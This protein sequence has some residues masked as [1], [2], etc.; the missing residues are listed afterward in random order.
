[1]TVGLSVFLHIWWCVVTL[2][3]EEKVNKEKTACQLDI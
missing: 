3:H 2:M 1:M